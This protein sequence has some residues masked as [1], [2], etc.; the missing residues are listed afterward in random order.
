[1]DSSSEFQNTE[2]VNGTTWHALARG[3]GAEAAWHQH[4]QGPRR[5]RSP[6][7]AAEI[8]T[9]SPAR[10]QEAR[11]F[12]ALPR[13]AQQHSRLRPARRR[14]REANARAVA[15]R[16]DHPRR[17]DPERTPRLHP[18]G[19]GGEGTR[20]HPQHALGRSADSARRRHAHD[21]GRGSRAGRHRAPRVGRQGAGGSAARRRQQSA[22]RGGGAH[23]RVSPGGE[24]LRSGRRKVH[25]R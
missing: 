16:R 24:G 7:P 23:R 6:E 20:L 17:G 9:E 8:R 19:Q 2:P 5:V 21:A 22:Y 10:R 11:A 18:G 12:R 1:M 3:R 15:R 4:R 13:A 25:C 14:L